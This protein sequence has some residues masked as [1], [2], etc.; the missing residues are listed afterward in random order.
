MEDY[1]FA[2]GRRG[3]RDR[4]DDR[5]RMMF[6]RR[7]N[8]TLI[9]RRRFRV[10]QHFLDHLE[11]D[12][13]ISFPVGDL[14]IGSHA[15][16][17]GVLIMR[18]Y[19]GQK[20]R[21]DF[22]KLVETL[23]PTEP[24]KSIEI[25]DAMIGYTDGDSITHSF[26]I[27]GCN[28]GKSEPFLAKLKE[29]LGDDVHV[30]APIHFHGLTPIPR[31]GIFE[32]MAYEFLVENPTRY[33]TRNEVVTAFEDKVPKEK[34]IDDTEVPSAAWGDK[35]ANWQQRWIPRRVKRTRKRQVPAPLGQAIGRLNTVNTPQQFRVDRVRYP[36][37]IFFANRNQ[38]PNALGDRRQ[39]VRDSI[40]GH[41]L[42]QPGHEYPFYEREGFGNFDD[43]FDSY[44]WNARKWK[45]KRCRDKDRNRGWCL[46][47]RGVKFGYTVVIPIT[48]PATGNLIFNF[49]PNAGSAEPPITTGLTVTDD[50]FFERV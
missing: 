49:Y 44:T 39:L 10:L 22:E 38:I 31:Y 32:Y 45:V 12:P 23:D 6:T 5:L 50:D 19:R 7:E 16:R 46:L 25:P 28:I 14:L 8:T 4:Q 24:A 13:G 3:G 2:P 29:A 18:M 26:D 42:F 20:G 15:N 21:T 47:A 33:R 34:L 48:D 17:T 40:E 11:N 27:K 43:W 9:Y 1:G 35:M 36:Y 30:S 37:R 41:E